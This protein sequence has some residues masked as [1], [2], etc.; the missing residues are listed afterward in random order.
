MFGN[1]IPSQLT[2]QEHSKSGQVTPIRSSFNNTRA[3]HIK[4]TESMLGA[5]PVIVEEEEIEHKQTR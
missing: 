2:N 1:S 5:M 3:S 4:L